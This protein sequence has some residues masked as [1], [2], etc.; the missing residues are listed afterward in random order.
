MQAT[1]DLLRTFGLFK[2]LPDSDIEL[3]CSKSVV[4]RYERRAVILDAGVGKNKICMLFDGRL[5][6][7]DF[8]IDGKE[9]GLYFVE[10]G[11]Y[12]G[13]LCVLIQALAR[14]CVL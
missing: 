3:L 12:C 9:V 10:P 1:S 14:T 11:D 4:K 2:A 13:E 5:Q 7:I 6:G 8:T